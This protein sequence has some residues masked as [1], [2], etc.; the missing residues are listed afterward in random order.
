MTSTI[1]NVIDFAREN[2]ITILEAAEE[3]ERFM[4]YDRNNIR[5]E[6][7]NTP[8]LDKT[9]TICIPRNMYKEHIKQAFQAGYG[10]TMRTEGRARKK[11]FNNLNM[12]LSLY[13]TE[14]S[15]EVRE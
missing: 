2:E 14:R 5:P 1:K 8:I 6:L 9:D 11:L 15:P 13:G 7:Q 4:E 12:Q 10:A 3:V